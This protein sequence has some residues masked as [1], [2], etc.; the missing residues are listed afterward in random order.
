MAR[1]QILLDPSSHE[2]R[3][4]I[5]MMSPLAIAAEDGDTR[6]VQQLLTEG[7]NVESKDCFGRTPLMTAVYAEQEA[8]VKLLLESNAAIGARCNQEHSPLTLAATKGNRDI[9][10]CLLHARTERVRFC[11]RECMKALQCAL[12]ENHTPIME[13][14]VLCAYPQED[15]IE[16]RNAVEQGRDGLIRF[17]RRPFGDT[18]IQDLLDFAIFDMISTGVVDEERLDQAIEVANWEE[19]MPMQLAVLRAALR[20][21]AHHNAC[22]VLQQ[23]QS[24]FARANLDDQVGP[25]MPAGIEA[26]ST[27]TICNDSGPEV[28]G[29]TCTICL[30]QNVI[31]D[32]VATLSCNHL[33]HLQCISNWL[34]ISN[35][36]PNCRQKG[37]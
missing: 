5:K 25:A 29:M 1:M 33:F 36:C 23:I 6:K 35:S 31:G 8:V 2:H 34:L 20:H 18:P 15:P 21:R 27:Q 3:R 26:L 12:H 30:Q 14:L 7:N 37:C 28:L 22:G 9:L 10:K 16:V 24:H 17:F 32:D 4:V 11:D 19:R 13:Q